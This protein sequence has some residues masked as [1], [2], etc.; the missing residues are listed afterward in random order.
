M[1]ELRGN[2]WG[3]C[4]P[5]SWNLQMLHVH[6]SSREFE[7][8][9]FISSYQRRLNI[10]RFDFGTDEESADIAWMPVSQWC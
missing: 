8:I 6:G 7:E 1:A 4:Y 2:G 5:Y 10:W 9:G 3:R